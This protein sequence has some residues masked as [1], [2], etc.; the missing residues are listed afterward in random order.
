MAKLHELLAVTGDLDGA[1][2]K[3]LSETIKTF[4]KRESYKSHRKIRKIR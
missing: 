1:F 3:I 2:R 4:T